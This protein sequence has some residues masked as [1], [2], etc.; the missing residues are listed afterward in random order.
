MKNV[1]VV[2]SSPRKNGN[3]EILAQKF[4][5]G[6]KSA[7]NQANI[8]A[9]CNI[10]LKFCTGCLY[11]NTHSKCVLN[12]GMNTLYENF[13]NADV[14]VF[15]TP[16]YYYSVCGQLKTLL[17]RLNPLFVRKN[18]FKD[19]YLLATA[20]DDDDSAMD[21]AIKDIQGWVSCFDGVTLKGVIRGI[22]VTDKGEINNTTYPQQAYE[23]GKNI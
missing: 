22:G 10:D 6:A 11:C 8:I 4:A 12:D 17:D 16:I 19:V 5:E 21:G 7:G 15:A 20:A 1:I 3:S 23:M 2:T 14:L 13:Q 9:V 18:K